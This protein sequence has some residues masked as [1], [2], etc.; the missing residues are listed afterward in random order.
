[1]TAVHTVEVPAGDGTADAYL[2]VPH[3]QGTSPGVLMFMDGFG[4]RPRL[5]AMAVRLAD[6]GYVV[7]VPNVFYRHGGAEALGLAE[8]TRAEDRTAMMEKVTPRI[9]A[10]TPDRAA[11]D[12]K[13][14]LAFLTSRDRADG[15]PVGA[16]GYCFGG[17]LAIRAAATAPELVA[18]AATFHGGR[19]ATDQ[20]DSPHLLAPQ[21]RAEVYLGH[22]DNDPS[23][24]PEQQR[25]LI[26]ALAAA[27]VR[28]QSEVYPGAA[29]G[30]TMADTAAYDADAEARHWDRMLDLFG[31]TL[32]R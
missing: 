15:G 26:E 19:L 3:G 11:R 21:L 16:V 23:M 20:P 6:H 14:F 13:A 1:M 24:P 27:G 18:A 25:T 29:H 28:H 12:A 5:A 8:L 2:A 9:A 7:L 31:R 17:S 10:V 4:L 22:A 30:F 32:T